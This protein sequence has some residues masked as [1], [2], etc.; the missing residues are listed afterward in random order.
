MSQEPEVADAHEARWQHVQKEA[1]QKLVDG[2]A[3]Q[4]LLVF[5]CRVAPPEGND[6]IG[7]C[8]EAVVGDG[9]AM[10]VSAEIVQDML[11][12]AKRPLGV[13]HPIGAEQGTEARSER[14][15]RLQPGQ[16]SGKSEFAVAVE[17][18]KTGDKLAAEHSAEDLDREEEMRRRADPAG[19]IGSQTAGRNDTVNMWM[20]EELL[21]PGMEHAEETDFRAE[22]ARIAS[23]G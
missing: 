17:L 15:W 18:A 8:H 21:V 19:V 9:N 10:G 2:Q 6:A 4:T 1:A 16:C 14:F 13:N 20:M 11:S 5:V 3:R 22:V 7:E 12:A 23:D